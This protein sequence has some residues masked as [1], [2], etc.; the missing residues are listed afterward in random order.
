MLRVVRALA[1]I[2][3]GSTSRLLIQKVIKGD[4]TQNHYLIAS[5]V[6]KAQSIV[7]RTGILVIVI[8]NG[9]GVSRM[10]HEFQKPGVP[11]CEGMSSGCTQQAT[12]QA[13]TAQGP[14]NPEIGDIGAGD[15]VAG[16]ASSG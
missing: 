7:E 1:V 15:Y 13:C 14:A 16:R 8:Y 5:L 6:I 10:N 2:K 9:A 11:V 3:Q 4:A 12:S